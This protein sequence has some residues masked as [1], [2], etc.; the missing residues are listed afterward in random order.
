MCSMQYNSAL[1]LL[2]RP[3][4]GF[5]I[6]GPPPSHISHGSTAEVRRICVRNAIDMAETLR[7]YENAHGEAFTMSGV[8][9]HPIS[10]AA[11]I[12]ISEII[13]YKSQPSS[14]KNS[15]MVVQYR[16]CLKQCVKSLSEMD[17]SYPVA[18]RV[19]KIIQLIM[20]LS[21]VGERSLSQCDDQQVLTMT[22][23]G[24]LPPFTSLS[25]S[26][27]SVT[28]SLAAQHSV[29]QAHNHNTAQH[30]PGSLP[31]YDTILPDLPSPQTGWSP[32]DFLFPE[33][34]LPMTSQMDIL[35]SFGS[36]FGNEY[37]V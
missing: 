13:D 7:G 25:A 30:S 17:K 22:T 18:K 2:N 5:G 16:R 35:Y 12:L 31:E 26:D 11:T 1:I 37:N 28:G 36:F 10:T 9:L 3:M 32:Q 14:D 6:R 24:I 19:R 8:A 27:S 21:N 23:T 29:H 34:G 33:D 15:A 20:R 4:A